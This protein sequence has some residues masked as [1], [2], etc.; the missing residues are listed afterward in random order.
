MKAYKLQCSVE[1]KPWTIHCVVCVT[2]E[3][4][5]RWVCIK[6]QL[7]ASFVSC[8]YGRLECPQTMMSAD[9][10]VIC[11]E[12]RE[13]VAGNIESGRMSVICSKTEYMC[14][15][16]RPKFKGGATVTCD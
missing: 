7:Q 11:T 8:D 12:S 3:F 2:E 13:Q 1:P 15:Y 10:T 4:K 14:E 6:N 9:D 5:G 16:G